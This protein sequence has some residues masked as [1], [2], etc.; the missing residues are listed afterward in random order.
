MTYT[1]SLPTCDSCNAVQYPS[2]EICRNCFSENITHKDTDASGILLAHSTIGHSLH[3]QFSTPAGW[4]IATVQLNKGTVL[5]VHLFDSAM[6]TGAKIRL[7][8]LMDPDGRRVFIA[9]PLSMKAISWEDLIKER[10][11]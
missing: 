6:T 9:L 7:Q 3:N 5:I 8:S 10:M 4:P 2:R 11:K 1:I